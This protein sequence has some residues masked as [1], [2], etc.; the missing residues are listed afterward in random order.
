M[1]DW[2]SNEAVLNAET[3]FSHVK[4]VIFLLCCSRVVSELQSV[5]GIHLNI[6]SFPSE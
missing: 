1:K 4:N 2:F 5:H 3:A 6:L